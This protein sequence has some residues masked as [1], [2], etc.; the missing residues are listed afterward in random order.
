[1]DGH[2]ALTY[3]CLDL[4]SDYANERVEIT[5][6]SYASVDPGP[7]NPARSAF[8]DYL[9][10][11]YLVD[12][13]H[14][15][16]RPFFDNCKP[17]DGRAPVWQILTVYSYEPD[18]GMDGKMAL[19]P[20]Q[21]LMGS[22]QAW[23]HE[24]FHMGLRFGRVTEMVEYFDRLSRIAFERG[25]R[26]WGF[27]FMARAVHYLQDSGTPYHT[28][29]GTA[30]DILKIP[31]TYRRQFRKISNYHKFHDRYTGYRLWRGYAPFLKA[32]WSAVPS[33]GFND[34]RR[35]AIEARN[36]GL[37][38]VK[39]LQSSIRAVAGDEFDTIDGFKG[40]R[41]YF[42][43]ISRERDTKELDSIT[44]RFLSGMAELV[45]SYLKTIH[46]LNSKPSLK[47]S[48]QAFT[49]VGS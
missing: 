25:D 39:D 9:G 2:D 45:K 32:I 6:Y 20:L 23:R 15:L 33:P 48:R 11:K 7:Y 24:E 4:E 34:P 8:E 10:E 31:F 37:K 26:Y 19:S 17:V 46:S 3:Y 42:D 47:I 40:D 14:E 12:S 5:P 18:F 36:R 44:V 1:M 41:A 29:P 16:Y 35:L 21:R 28:S 27:R 22:S 49:T 30:R 43:K 13:D 38:L